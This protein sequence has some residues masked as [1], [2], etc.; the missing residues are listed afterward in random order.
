MILNREDREESEDREDREDHS[1]TSHP[2][3]I[4]LANFA[5]FAH[6]AVNG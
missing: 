1:D 3:R 6:V 5:I 2:T 4:F